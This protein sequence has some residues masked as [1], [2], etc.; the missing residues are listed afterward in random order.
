MA[1]C[2]VRLVAL[3]T[4]DGHLFVEPGLTRDTQVLNQ[5]IIRFFLKV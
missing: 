5:A 1:I 2:M 4:N 3:V